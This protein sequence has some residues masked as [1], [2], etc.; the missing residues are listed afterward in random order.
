ME[1][2]SLK[3]WWKRWQVVDSVLSLW[4]RVPGWVKAAVLKAVAP[5]LAL[6]TAYAVTIA[7]MATGV[8]QAYWPHM[9]LAAF[10]GMGAGTPV[11]YALYKAHIALGMRLEDIRTR[12]RKV[13]GAKKGTDALEHLPHAA[14]VML[15]SIALEPR[16]LLDSQ[17]YEHKNMLEDAGLIKVVIHDSRHANH[18]YGVPEEVRDQ[19]TDFFNLEAPGS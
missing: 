14:K 12:R 8:V 15:A 5:L 17:E 3:V 1:R 11:A 4:D 16:Q 13:G 18:V 9:V 6:A 2:S 19:V 10:L 7:V